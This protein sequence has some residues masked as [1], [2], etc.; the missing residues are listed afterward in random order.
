MSY[1]TA[2]LLLF[3]KGRGVLEVLRALVTGISEV[4]VYTRGRVSML[5]LE[6][7][8]TRRM[9]RFNEI[10]ARSP[11]SRITA[12]LQLS[13]VNELWA[14]PDL[15]EENADL[16]REGKYFDLAAN[17]MWQ[18]IQNFP[19]YMRVSHKLAPKSFRICAEELLKKVAPIAETVGIVGHAFT[20]EMPGLDM[21][22]MPLVGNVVGNIWTEKWCYNWYQWR[23]LLIGSHSRVVQ[24]GQEMPGRI[25]VCHES[26]AGILPR[27]ETE[28]G[29]GG[30]EFFLKD[31]L[32]PFERPIDARLG[33]YKI[34]GKY[35]YTLKRRRQLVEARMIRPPMTHH[36]LKPVLHEACCGCLGWKIDDVIAFDVHSA[37][38]ARFDKLFCVSNL[39]GL[40][41]TEWRELHILAWRRAFGLR[42]TIRESLAAL[43]FG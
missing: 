37:G 3:D 12:D 25:L 28:S 35:L 20:T 6:E 17:V 38:A 10:E 30:G 34:D 26:L 4:A 39:R 40:D 19:T 24:L 23:P 31:K 43:Y 29:G 13:P 2:E 7:I 9:L 16:G 33:E 36:L 15:Q 1:L 22:M 42:A 8:G 41:R 14:P 32:A 5:P 18:G 27:A 11:D 21:L